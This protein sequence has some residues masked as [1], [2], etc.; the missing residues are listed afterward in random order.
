MALWRVLDIYKR[1]ASR[2]GQAPDKT[3][4]TDTFTTITHFYKVIFKIKISKKNK[5]INMSLQKKKKLAKYHPL[6]KEIRHN[7]SLPLEAA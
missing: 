7:V 3:Q 2:R 5:L 4:L 6:K 1:G